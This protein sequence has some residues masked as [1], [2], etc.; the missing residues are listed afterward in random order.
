MRGCGSSLSHAIRRAGAVATM[1]LACCACPREEEAILQLRD[2]VLG[3]V[4]DL[5]DAWP[6]WLRLLEA[7]H[8]IEGVF[9]VDDPERIQSQPEEWLDAR[10]IVSRVL[11]GQP[12]TGA[13]TF[14]VFNTTI[15]RWGYWPMYSWQIQQANGQQCVAF[16]DGKH[17]VYSAEGKILPIT[18]ASELASRRSQLKSFLCL[19][20]LD[21]VQVAHLA[22]RHDSRVEAVVDKLR[23]AT[24]NTDAVQSCYDELRAMGAGAL[25][26]VLQAMLQA[27]LEPES[28]RAL[29]IAGVCL[30][31]PGSSS[32]EPSVKA[33]DVFDLLLLAADEV[34]V[35]LPPYGDPEGR[36]RRVR[37]FALHLLESAG[38]ARL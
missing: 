38:R 16:L 26:G 8:V 20:K 10:V 23:T 33:D 24:G 13:R 15:R 25:P 5:R 7:S 34:L 18:R 1:L 2:E 22:A 29:K 11:V 36:W 27:L 9:Q 37:I 4:A 31:P 12:V 6:D 32:N 28:N 19:A 30:R 17:I 35:G 21:P 3:H 14:L